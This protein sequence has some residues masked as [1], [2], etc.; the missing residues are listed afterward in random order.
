MKSKI[1][2]DW[3]RLAFNGSIL[4]GRKGGKFVSRATGRDASG[5]RPSTAGRTRGLAFTEPCKLGK[6]PEFEI[7]ESKGIFYYQPRVNGKFGKR[8]EISE[9]L[10][11]KLGA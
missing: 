11:K 5:N 8:M 3:D 1:T 2:S 6:G 7:K 4:K 9:S 10:A